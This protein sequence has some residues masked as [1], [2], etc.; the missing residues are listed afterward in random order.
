MR[1]GSD[2]ARYC[3]LLDVYTILG[4]ASTVQFYLYGGEHIITYENG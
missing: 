3:A 1:N 4:H 2:D